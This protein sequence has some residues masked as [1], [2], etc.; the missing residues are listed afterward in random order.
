MYVLSK[1]KQNPYLKANR[2]N[3]QNVYKAVICGKKYFLASHFF[4]QMFIVSLYPKAK[5][6]IVSAKAVVRVDLHAYA[7]SMHERNHSE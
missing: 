1:H 5:Y 6:Q 4:T 3:W 2:K 7:L